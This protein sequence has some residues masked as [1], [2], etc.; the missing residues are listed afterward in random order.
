M[1]FTTALGL[2]ASVSTAF[3]DVTLREAAQDF[4]FG[5]AANTKFFNNSTYLETVNSSFNTMVAENG[6]KFSS[7]H[8]EKDVYDFEDC[9][10]HLAKAEEFGMQFRGHCLLW[11]GFQPEWFRNLKGDDMRNAIIDHVTNVLNHYKGKVHIWDVVNEAV[12]DESS[13]ENG[14]WD[15]RKTNLAQEVPDFIDVA[16]KTA[17]E[18]DPTVKLYYND[19]NIEG[20]DI[21]EGKKTNSVYNLLKDMKE[22]GVPVDGVGLQYHLHT[23][24]YVKYENVMK[25]M[26][27][28]NEIGLDVQ[29]TEIDVNSVDGA[30]QEVFEFQ[31]SLYEDALRACLD[32]SNCT[33]FLIWGVDDPH[34]WR[35]EGTPLIFDGN[36]TPKPAYFS[37]LNVFKEYHHIEDSDDEEDVNAEGETD[38]VDSADEDSADE[39]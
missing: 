3:A 29:I 23:N 12:S 26:A 11:H 38:A 34:S 5:V 9:D 20:D 30:T 25:T 6:C 4:M 14:T 17:R 32:S 21:S 10:A 35:A 16:F 31:A 28:F 1:K 22:R 27:K 33:G 37:L 8:P 2:V 36:Y 18:V 19:Y 39:N 24:I 15:L 13:G 7:V